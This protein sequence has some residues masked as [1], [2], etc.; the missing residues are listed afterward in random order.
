MTGLEAGKDR[1]IEVAA[2]ITGADLK[3]LHEGFERIVHCPKEVMDSMD[4]WC[5]Q[6][7]G[8]VLPPHP[9]VPLV[10]FTFS[11]RRAGGETTDGGEWLDGSSARVREYGCGS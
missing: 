1:I 8:N 11:L 5:V 7:H 2:I 9:A 4:E 3:P 10:F 6:H